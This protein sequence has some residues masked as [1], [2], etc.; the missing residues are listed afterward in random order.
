MSRVKTSLNKTELAKVDSFVEN[1]RQNI[2]DVYK[3]PSDRK[4][5]IVQLLL[6]QCRILEGSVFTVVGGNVYK[7][8]VAF[9]L[10]NTHKL[11]YYGACL[12]PD[13]IDLDYL[14]KETLDKI[15]SL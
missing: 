2:Y 9:L 13:I 11:Y 4:I 10:K 8:Q 3:N 14:D 7:V 1:A 15:L 5:S 12:T 6:E